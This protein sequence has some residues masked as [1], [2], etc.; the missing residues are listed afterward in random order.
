MTDEKPMSPEAVFLEAL[1]RMANHDLDGWMAL[2]ADDV[3]FEFPFAPSGRPK[4]L[5]GKAAVADYLS[6]L[7]GSVE[8]TGPPA[9][10]VHHTTD[11]G[12]IVVEMQVEGRVTATG[13]PYAQ[14]YVVIL[15]VKDGLMTH[16]R[17]YWNPLVALD[18]EKVA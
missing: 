5:E 10:T 13:N 14:G 15:V 7:P 16:Y 12:T 11:P 18:L 3:V 4:R 8:V 17:D 2:C 1:S 6:H 9:L